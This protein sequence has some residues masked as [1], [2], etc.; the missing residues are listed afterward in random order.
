MTPQDPREI[1]AAAVPRRLLA[2]RFLGDSV[3]HRDLDGLC[4]T[5][6]VY[7]RGTE[8]PVHAHAH[9]YLSFALEGS[10][11]ET[12]NTH[13]RHCETQTLLFH[14]A[15]ECHADSFA[16]CGGRVLSI[17][18]APAWLARLLTPVRQFDAPAEFRQGPPCWLMHRLHREWSDW[19]QASPLALEG[20]V[21]E[22]LASVARSTAARRPTGPAWIH[23]LRTVMAT[24]FAEPLTLAQL[25]GIAGI[26]PTHLIRAFRRFVGCT[27]AAFLRQLR[28][29]HACQRL[30][31]SDDA[32]SAIALA[33]GF[34][35]QS[36]LCKAF[37]SELGQTP[38][39]FRKNRAEANPDQVR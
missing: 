34:C 30:A 29:R 19:D 31:D 16:D 11:R 18:I 14:P 32:L 2:G 9:A 28:I 35:D 17:E 27:P 7:P 4:F 23:E 5:E 13:T 24:R 37:R 3:R 20:L 1:A 38:S 15:G 26:H 21:L 22:V 39:Q 6:S 33:S 25:A 10:Y 8:L 12:A 36:H